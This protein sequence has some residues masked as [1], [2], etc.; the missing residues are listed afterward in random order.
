M[1]VAKLIKGL[2]K[3]A[4]YT[5]WSHIIYRY[6]VQGGHI[7]YT[8]DDPK[9]EDKPNIKEDPKNEDD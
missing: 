1:P 6:R 8:E 9:Y 4:L 3:Q 5:G 2:Q 7:L